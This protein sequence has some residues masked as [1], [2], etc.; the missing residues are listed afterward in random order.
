M[1]EF[2]RSSL[3]L[4]TVTDDDR[5]VVIIRGDVDSATAPQL[6]AVVEGLRQDSTYIEFDM[7]EL[8]FLDS[9]GLGVIAAGLRRLEPVD[10]TLALREVPA[11]VMRLLRITDLLRFVEVLS[12]RT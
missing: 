5:T 7:S 11:S 6:L 2:P 10:G 12:E 3:R 9:T 1:T 4:D 8:G